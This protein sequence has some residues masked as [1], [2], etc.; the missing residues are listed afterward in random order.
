MVRDPTKVVISI[1]N[2]FLI[3]LTAVWVLYGIYKGL[4]NLEMAYNYVYVIVTIMTLALNLR[5][6]NK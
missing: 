5:I 4:E 2:V 1:L 3:L 6:I